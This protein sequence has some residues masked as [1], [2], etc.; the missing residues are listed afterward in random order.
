[1]ALDRKIQEGEH[2]RSRTRRAA[3]DLALLG[4]ATR[5][6]LVRRCGLAGV[7]CVRV[8]PRRW[9]RGRHLQDHL[10]A[11]IAEGSKRVFQPHFFV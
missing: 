5:G 4:A 7:M 6:G 10:W 1:M 8:R 3:M 11:E 2:G 9:R